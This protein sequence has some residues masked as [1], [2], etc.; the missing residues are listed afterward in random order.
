MERFGVLVEA[1]RVLGAAAEREAVAAGLGALL[2]DAVGDGVVLTLD[3]AGA[4][5]RAPQAFAGAGASALWERCLQ[6]WARGPG[7]ALAPARAAGAEP[8]SPRG[9]WLDALGLTAEDEAALRTD[10]PWWL[11]QLP[12]GSHGWL[13]LLRGPSGRGFA[14]PE[15]ELVEAVVALAAVALDRA[16]VLADERALRVRAEAELEA[17]LE[18]SHL[19]RAVLDASPAVIH[20]V[21]RAGRYLFVNETWPRT[22]GLSGGEMLGKSLFDIWPRETAERMWRDDLEVLKSGKPIQAEHEV[23]HPSGPRQY[24]TIKAPLLDRHGAVAG[25]CGIST[26]ITSRIKMEVALRQSEER[27]AK[28][29]RISPVAI[30][31]TRASDGCFLDANEQCLELAGCT[32]EELVGR[33]GVEL[34]LW[35]STENREAV[36]SAPR[37]G[38]SVRAAPLQLHRRSGE[39][40][41]VLMSLEHIRMGD[42]DCL[43]AIATDITEYKRLEARLGQAVK[44]EAI[45]RLAGGVAHDFNN[46]L[47]TISGYSDMLLRS[48]PPESTHHR[49]V[50]SIRKSSTRAAS[51]TRQLLLFGRKQAMR[52]EVLQLN[53]VVQGLAGLLR[54]LLGEDV[55]LRFD[56]DPALQR[57]RAD[58]S[59]L[60]QVVVNLA[61]NARDAMPQGGRLTLRTSNVADDDAPQVR[62]TVRDEGVGMSAETR[63]RIFEPFF[64]TKELGKGTG[65]GLSSVYSIVEQSGGRIE[66]ESMPGEGSSFH[67]YLPAV[68][69]PLAPHEAERATGTPLMGT[70]TVLLVEDDED[71]RGFAR[72][73]LAGASYRV[74][75]AA[76]GSAALDVAQRFAGPIHVLVSDCVMPGMSGP[77][78]AAHLRTLRPGLKVVLVSGYPGGL[79]ARGA[80]DAFLEKPFAAEVL[81]QTVRALLD[82]AGGQGGA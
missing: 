3:G 77:A 70:E 42:V 65:L 31:I 41:D 30:A 14:E 67:V 79:D 10:E 2:A 4:E 49:W 19:T 62:L 58:A 1:G 82:G 40:R 8:S 24:L 17:A 29:F 52:V 71:V 18:L 64:T 7:A 39:P 44:M 51:L 11:L 59:L 43:L 73:T 61:G 69:A 16:R 68:V 48:L 56:L 15:R 35:P 50:D 25:V 5:G 78:V 72:H 54:R 38:F 81:L 75:E 27:F 23:P 21:D 74:L 6:G 12:V 36:V 76:D 53:D 66:V 80:A 55:E 32:L 20:V 37:E 34:G 47:T 9:P 46:I 45:G 28:V 57:T 26:D 33:S 60:E 13:A 63:E 22:F